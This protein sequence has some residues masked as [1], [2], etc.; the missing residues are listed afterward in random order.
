MIEYAL[1][2]RGRIN[3]V[4]AASSHIDIVTARTEMGA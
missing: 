3:F 1:P 4:L 2:E